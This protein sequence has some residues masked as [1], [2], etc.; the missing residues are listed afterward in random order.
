MQSR[1][2]VFIESTSLFQLG[3]RLDRVDFAKLLDWRPAAGFE[4]CVTEVS[5][6]EFMRE[7]KADVKAALDKLIQTRTTLAKYGQNVDFVDQA[8]ERVTTYHANLDTAFAEKA[9]QQD[10]L[11]LPTAAV[12]VNRLLKMS[13]NCT[14]PFELSNEKGFRDALI[15]FTIL[16]NIRGQSD[17]EHIVISND[18][19][20]SDAL[21][22][23]AGEFET[24]VKVVKDFEEATK[25][26]FSELSVKYQEQLKRESEEAKALLARF[27]EQISAYVRGIKEVSLLAYS[28]MYRALIGSD[29]RFT[30]EKV[31]GV[32]FEGI[33]AALWRN[34]NEKVSTILFKIK[35][36]VRALVSEPSP[37]GYKFPRFVVGQPR[38][39]QSFLTLPKSEERLLPKSFFGEAKLEKRD[40]GLELTSLQ[41]EETRPD[42]EAFVELLRVAND[43]PSQIMS[44]EE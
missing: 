35:C 7:R 29:E 31:L 22:S 38:Q 34:K 8:V 30:V 13:I 19:L 6:L 20:L 14:P 25:H 16:Y 12:D 41:I 4:L 10:I 36:A 21:L 2:K 27:E 44:P 11:I 26:I 9:K 33:E 3:P 40:L 37:S 32:S 24:A 39:Y 28:P 15:V 23:M 18:T 5:W 42:D 1:R 43:E 17:V